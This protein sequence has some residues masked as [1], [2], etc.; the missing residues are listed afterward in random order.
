MT[1]LFSSGRIV[2]LILALMVLEG[3]LLVG[4]HRLTGK[5]PAPLD[6]VANLLAGALLLAALR[7]ALM[8]AH[9]THVALWLLAAFIAHLADLARRW[10]GAL[11]PK[12]C[13]A[14]SRRNLSA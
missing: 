3:L 6:V 4:W 11:A 13:G 9:W 10:R 1:E 8:G 5:G 12:A 7:A 14:D 2:D